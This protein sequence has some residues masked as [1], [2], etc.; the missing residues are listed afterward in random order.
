[1]VSVIC[2]SNY[3]EW[4][5]LFMNFGNLTE[6]ELNIIDGLD[7][8]QD[9]RIFENGYPDTL[10]FTMFCKVR[11]KSRY[12]VIMTTRGVVKEFKG[13]TTLYAFMHTNCPRF[14]Y[15]Q[16]SNDLAFFSMGLIAQNPKVE[17]AMEYDKSTIA[18]KE[19]V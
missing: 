4:E 15:S 3:L 1:M 8:I 2:N 11:N 17:K 12:C 6:R 9:I 18:E 19:V 13:F 5:Y 7:G 14:I 10:N 16:T